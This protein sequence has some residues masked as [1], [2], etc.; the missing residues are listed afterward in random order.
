MGHGPVA[1]PNFED[2]S[3]RPPR[4][5]CRQTSL[6]PFQYASLSGYDPFPSVGARMKRPEFVGFLGDLAAWP[7]LGLAV[8]PTL[9]ARPDQ[10]IE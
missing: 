2:P 8:P 7:P 1:G 6:R 3:G 4:P 9:L 10:V 5:H